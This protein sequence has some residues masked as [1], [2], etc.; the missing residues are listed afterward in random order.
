MHIRVSIILDCLN[1]WGVY[2]EDKN[3]WFYAFGNLFYGSN[4][5]LYFK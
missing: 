2:Y 1:I 5:R 3:I 4:F